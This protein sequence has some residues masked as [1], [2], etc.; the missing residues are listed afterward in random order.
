MYKYIISLYLEFHNCFA[1]ER[2]IKEKWKSNF[3]FYFFNKQDFGKIEQLEEDFVVTSDNEEILNK[4]LNLSNDMIETIIIHWWNTV[5][6]KLL[7]TLLMELKK[8]SGEVLSCDHTYGVVN[9]IGIQQDDIWVLYINRLYIL[10]HILVSIKMFII[11][12]NE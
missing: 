3:T 12:Y 7:S 2:V 8:T 9:S 11:G 6:N 10:T 1:I 4:L 5:G